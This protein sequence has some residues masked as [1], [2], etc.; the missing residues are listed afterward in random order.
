M[1]HNDFVNDKKVRE[2]QCH[3]KKPSGGQLGSGG[4]LKCNDTARLPIVFLLSL[5]LYV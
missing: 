5:P 4:I 3:S 1:N 2:K